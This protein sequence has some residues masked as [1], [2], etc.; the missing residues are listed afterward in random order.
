MVIPIG[1][2]KNDVSKETGDL[3]HA[4]YDDKTEI[5][6]DVSTSIDKM[7]LSLLLGR[8]DRRLQMLR[9]SCLKKT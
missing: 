4:E 2:S 9:S 1:N 8:C 7:L 5:Q 3:A 6:G